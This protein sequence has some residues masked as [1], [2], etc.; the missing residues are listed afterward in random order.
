GY[1]RLSLPGRGEPCAADLTTR[2]AQVPAQMPDLAG[3]ALI[4]EVHVYGQ[5]LAVGAEA[6]G[7][8]QHMGLGTALL[9]EARRL[10]AA[11]GFR[12]LAVIAAVGTR[13]YYTARGFERGEN[14]LVMDV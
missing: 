8:A 9:A 12:R 5:A 6:P 13:A 2:L 11:A 14:Y 3:A 10:A 1:L 4:R 7:A